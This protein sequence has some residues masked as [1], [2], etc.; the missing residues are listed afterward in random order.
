MPRKSRGRTTDA[1]VEL[2][3]LYPTLCDLAGIPLPPHLEGYSFRPLLSEPS[4][5]WKE[6]AL[7]QFPT[8]ALRE[9]A[10]NP[11][12]QGMRETFF[13][14]LIEEVEMRII[15]QQRKKWD[16]DLFENRLMGYTMRTDRYRLVVWRDHQDPDAEPIFVELYDHERDPAET[17]NVAEANP[18]VV[19]DLL[20]QF[21]AGWKG[22]LPTIDK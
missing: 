20:V 5:S 6:A 16:R 8:P 22:S 12:S 13:G 10:A 15:D 19:A 9:W 17:V 4:Q 3:D 14:P 2:V 11:L 7:S 21:E 1:L 18:K